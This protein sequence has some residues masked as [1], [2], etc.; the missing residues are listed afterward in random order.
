M[1][2]TTVAPPRLPPIAVLGAGQALQPDAG[3]TRSVRIGEPA[4]TPEQIPRAYFNGLSANVLSKQY[5]A[6]AADLAPLDYNGI[7]KRVRQP[8]GGQ[9]L[10]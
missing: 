6:K 2:S 3:R 9:L 8:S 10:V 1:I 7:Y 4:S 5:K